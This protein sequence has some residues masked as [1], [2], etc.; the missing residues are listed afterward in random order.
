L[1][2]SRL[3]ASSRTIGN[4]LNIFTGVPLVW[5]ETIIIKCIKN[6]PRVTTI[7]IYLFGGWGKEERK[8]RYKT[9]E[10][11]CAFWIWSFGSICPETGEEK[12]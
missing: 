5:P 9:Q 6:N 8:K 3:E 7:K 12:R 2:K 4:A 1:K 11:Q 10:F